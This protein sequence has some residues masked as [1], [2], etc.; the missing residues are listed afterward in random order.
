MSTLRRRLVGS[1]AL[2]AAAVVLTVAVRVTP[3]VLTASAT[4]SSLRVV[5]QSPLSL[6]ATPALLAAE[7]VLMVGG[8]AAVADADL[9]ARATLLAPPVSA[10]LAVTLGVSAAVGV[11]PDATSLSDA[12]VAAL[13]GPTAS[14]AAGAVVGGAV[15]PVVRASTT[16]DTAALLGGAVL[17]LV[18]IAAA[19]D[20]V[21]SLVAGG[22]GGVVAVA[23]LW[24]ADPE[25]W[26][27]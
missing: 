10:L 4:D 26:R 21:R 3:A 19:P 18:S 2:L 20:A 25:A 11:F 15:A 14:V 9:S 5:T 16:E 24:V 1:V 6:L 13:V 27:P 22:L 12:L 7:S 23:A 8:I 17:L